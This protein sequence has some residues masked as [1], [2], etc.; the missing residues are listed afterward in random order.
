[1]DWMHNR[2]RFSGPPENGNPIRMLIYFI[3]GRDYLD[4]LEDT[5]IQ[6]KHVCMYLIDGWEEAIVGCDRRTKTKI[7]CLP[8]VSSVWNEGY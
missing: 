8:A 7:A 6:V 5:R 1:L 2:R 4:A 3:L